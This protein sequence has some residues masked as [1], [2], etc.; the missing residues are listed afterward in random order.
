MARELKYLAECVETVAIGTV[1]LL[2]T[3]PC[4]CLREIPREPMDLDSLKETK[5]FT[6]LFLVDVLVPVV[7]MTQQKD[8][9]TTYKPL[10]GT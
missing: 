8:T 5:N 2:G 6:L 9:V 3:P 4:P 10:P 1:T 7:I